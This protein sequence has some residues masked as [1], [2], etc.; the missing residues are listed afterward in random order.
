[1]SGGSQVVTGKRMLYGYGKVTVLKNK[2]KKTTNSIVQSF[3]PMNY[4]S[5]AL[6]KKKDPFF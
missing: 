6:R 4:Y 3:L 5:M 2:H 1:M